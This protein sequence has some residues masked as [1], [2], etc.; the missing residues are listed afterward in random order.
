MKPLLA[1]DN[2]PNWSTNW[3][4]NS[5]ALEKILLESWILDILHSQRIELED[6]YDMQNMELKELFWNAYF[7][8]KRYLKL[9]RKGKFEWNIEEVKQK[10]SFFLEVFFENIPTNEI[11]EHLRKRQKEAVYKALNFIFY[12]KNQ[13]WYINFATGTGKTVMY[14]DI[15]RNIISQKPDSKI[16]VMSPNLESL[17]R[18][19]EEFQK[20]KLDF[21][22]FSQESKTLENNLTIATVQ[23]LMRSKDFKHSDYDLVICDEVHEQFMWEL[24]SEFMDKF[25]C[26]KL[27]FTATPE[28]RDKSVE[29]SFPVLIDEYLI[30]WSNKK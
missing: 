15:I 7:E 30:R 11:W 19:K 26:K 29:Q 12:N 16:L 5:K 24:T 2:I 25:T 13:W 6:L 20:L 3:T 8:L 23:S 10:I 27:W 14:S 4:T 1:L 21:G 28:L 18:S 22:Q 9:L 17:N